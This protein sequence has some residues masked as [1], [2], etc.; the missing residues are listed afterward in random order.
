MSRNGI[1]IPCKHCITPERFEATLNKAINNCGPDSERKRTLLRVKENLPDYAIM[2]VLEAE[3]YGKFSK[4]FVN[5][6]RS[7]YDLKPFMDVNYRGGYK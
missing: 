1:L 5:M 4:E 7:A 3:N 6:L 2:A